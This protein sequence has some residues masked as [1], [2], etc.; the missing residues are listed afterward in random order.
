MEIETDCAKPL[1]ETYGVVLRF[2]NWLIEQQAPVQD[3]F[4]YKYAPEA[5]LAVRHRKSFRPDVSDQVCWLDFEAA[6]RH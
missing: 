5:S 2:A 4:K 3:G 6:T 1:Q